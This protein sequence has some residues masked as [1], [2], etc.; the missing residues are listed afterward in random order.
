MPKVDVKSAVQ[1][2]F[3]YLKSF[4]DFMGSQL[5]NLRLE[6]VELSDNEPFWLITLGFDVPTD[7]EFFGPKQRREYKL[8]KVNS[9]TGQVQAMKIREV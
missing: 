2:A 6:E 1:L 5:E 3:E 7:G 8:L 9:E 4:Q